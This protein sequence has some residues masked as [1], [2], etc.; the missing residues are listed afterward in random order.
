[1]RCRKRQHD[2]ALG[3]PVNERPQRYLVVG[4]L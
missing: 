1:V 3:G 4:A 2:V